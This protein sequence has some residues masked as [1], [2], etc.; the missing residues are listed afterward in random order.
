M[1]QYLKLSTLPP[2]QLK[3]LMRRAEQDIGDLLSLAQSVIDRVRTEGD[4]AVVEYTRKLDAPNYDA[5]MLRATPADFAA[6]RKALSPEVIDALEQA[7]ANIQ[8]FHEEQMPEPMWFAEVQPGVMAGER[9]TPVTSAGLY[10][11]RGKGAFPSVM[12]MLATPAKVAGVPRIVVV[13]PPT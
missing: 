7:H 13:T 12:L 2:A 11:P 5:T 10:V 9:V 3:S 1:V 6:A 4:A 8:R